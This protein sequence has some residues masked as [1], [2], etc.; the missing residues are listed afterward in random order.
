MGAANY[1]E[2]N[3]AGFWSYGPEVRIAVP[4]TVAQNIGA[5]VSGRIELRHQASKWPCG[6]RAIPRQKLTAA[7]LDVQRAFFDG[8]TPTT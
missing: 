4:S 5:E 1:Y 8:N 2:V 3:V 7:R 6:L